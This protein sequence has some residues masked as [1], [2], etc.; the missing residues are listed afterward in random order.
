MKIENVCAHNGI[1][2]VQILFWRNSF[3]SNTNIIGINLYS[4]KFSGYNTE[5]NNETTIILPN[6][7]QKEQWN[8]IKSN[9]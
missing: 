4:R 1:L 2:P 5:G 7:A 8:N 3:L 6:M 9:E